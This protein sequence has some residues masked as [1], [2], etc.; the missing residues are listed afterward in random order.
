MSFAAPLSRIQYLSLALTSSPSCP[1]YRGHSEHPQATSATRQLHW[2]QQPNPTL[3]MQHNVFI[4]PR[5]GRHA[6]QGPA[7]Q[8]LNTGKQNRR[9]IVAL[10]LTICLSL[11]WD[12]LSARTII[13]VW[14]RTQVLQRKIKAGVVR[15][16]LRPL[17]S[18]S[19]WTHRLFWGLRAA[20]P[21]LC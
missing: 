16:V 19:C 1:T 17:L 12:L 2:L 13:C 14:C 5:G 6:S 15:V 8:Q 3:L 11:A 21:G 9:A 20:L 10:H 4:G 7:L 18:V